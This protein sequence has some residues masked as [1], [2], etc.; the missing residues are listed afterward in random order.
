[1]SHP[2]ADA[3]RKSPLQEPVEPSVNGH[4]VP[5]A[6]TEINQDAES[7]PRGPTRRGISLVLGSIGPT[8]VLA[9][10]AAV[11][12]YGHHNDWRIP[13]FAALT[14]DVEPVVD[15]WCEEHAVPES[16]CVECDP[17]LMAKGPDYGWCSVHGVHNC[18]LDHPDVAQ[19][20]ESP[21]VPVEDLERAAR[22]LAIAP[23]KENN[24][25]CEVYQSR[26]QFA[27]IESV[28]QAGVDVELVERAPITE[29]IVGNGEIIYDP[30][31]Q[32]SMASR[33]PGSV[34][35]V[36]KNVGD[37]VEVGEVLAVIDAAGVG[38]IKTD[39]LRALA[40]QKLQQQN[41][42]RLSSARAAI[43]GSRILDANAALA[44]AQADVLAAEQS[45]RNLGLP[46]EVGELQGL[47]EQQ[48]LDRLRLLGI[49][50]ELRAQ[51]NSRTVTSNL[52]PIRSPIQ[53]VVVQR[54]VSA[55][56][57]VDP[58]RILFQV[59][60]VR[61]MWLTLNIPLESSEQLAIG[62]PVEFRAD[63]SRE[64]VTGTLDWI[65]TSADN[66]TRMLQVRAVLDNSD[67]RLRNETFGMGEVILRKESD[68]IVI[69]TGSSHWEGCCQVVFVRDKD[70]FASPESYK[71]FHVRSVRLGAVNG[72]VTEI[73][74]GVLPG[75]VIATDGS[76]VLR[77]QLLK[78]NLGAGCDCVAE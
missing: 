40:E 72:D 8:L 56:E 55:G 18:T 41:V 29:S 58:T 36:T 5:A 24:S 69:P 6:E 13:K 20:K 32:A 22:A 27:S 39:L 53:G 43:A 70:Y 44:K 71:V 65:S 38:D 25:A 12:Y 26:I 4:K 35:K 59:A 3:P 33:V 68:A 31:R 11:F 66:T 60:D 10:F 37:P 77:A 74:S 15:D 67:G 45:L 47:S 54:S 7:K 64:V 76:D 51:L 1:M 78:N 50:D 2:L 17:T 9:G 46:A 34:W 57:V 16:I 52:L 63:G 42:S 21:T 14:G 19:L 23:R 61:Q 62:Q 28:Q 49:P 73:I 75:E 48:V 30:T